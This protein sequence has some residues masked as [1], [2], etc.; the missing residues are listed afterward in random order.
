M[1]ADEVG[2]YHVPAKSEMLLMTYTTHHHA[3][4]WDRPEEFIPERFMSEQTSC[5]SAFRLF[6][7]WRRPTHM[8]RQQLRANGSAVGSCRSCSEVPLAISQ[9]LHS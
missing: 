8:H 4:F 3:D 9:R 7:V 2:G 1:E 5:A 6:S